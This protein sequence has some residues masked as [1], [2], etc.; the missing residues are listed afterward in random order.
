M[1]LERRLELFES[2]SIPK[3]VMTLCI[4]TVLANIV[5]IIYSLADTYFVGM[6]GSPVETAAVTLA[7]PLLLLFNAFNNLF[8]IGCTSLMSRSLGSRDYGAVKRVSSFGFWSTLILAAIYSMLYT[9]FSPWILN[10]L[11]VLPETR[12]ATEAYLRWTVSFGAVP[13]ILNVVMSHFVRSEGAAFHASIGTM[14]G[15]IINIFLDPFFVLPWGLGLGAGGAGLATFI[16]NCIAVCYFI[17]LILRKRRR[18][19]TFLSISLKDFAFRSSVFFGIC[20]VGI[21]ACTGDCIC[22]V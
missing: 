17:I 14:S 16:S 12:A 7:Y 15:C 5:T 19:N 8:G 22:S 18:G 20:A 11:G 3:A 6:L 13:A 4:P 1:E 10:M 9:A 2:A 21:P